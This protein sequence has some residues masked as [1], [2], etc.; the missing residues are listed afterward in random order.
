MTSV[1]KLI[2]PRGGDA[3]VRLGLDPTGGYRIRFQYRNFDTSPASRRPRSRRPAR[4][5]HVARDALPATGSVSVGVAAPPE[6]L[7]A[8]VSDPSTPARFS[9]ELVEA[10]LR[11]RR[12]PARRR[13]YRGP[14]RNAAR[15]SGRRARRWSTASRPR[16]FA[17]ATGG[18][19][20][21]SATWS[22]EVA[23]AGTGSTLTHSRRVP[24]GR[25]AARPGDRG[26]AR[27]APRDRRDADGRGARPRCGSSSRASPRSPTATSTRSPA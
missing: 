5:R 26:R 4:L 15:S 3:V 14:Q 6:A 17:W 20:A 24:R 1:C 18:A 9:P 12:L 25:R 27:R 2:H 8:L 7:W 11:R 16:C 19:E 13:R 23:P 21:P 22:F 10:A